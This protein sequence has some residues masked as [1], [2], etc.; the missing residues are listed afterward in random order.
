MKR[1]NKKGFT[2]VELLAAIVILAVLMLVGAQAVGTILNNSNANSLVNSLDMAIK[3]ATMKYAEGTLETCPT[4]DDLD[5]VL[6]YDKNQYEIK[7]CYSTAGD[8]LTVKIIADKNGKFKNTKCKHGNIK[9]SD[10]FEKTGD[11]LKKEVIYTT[12]EKK[13]DKYKFEC[14]DIGDEQLQDDGTKKTV[15]NFHIIKRVE[16]TD[17]GE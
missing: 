9:N 8:H 1:L 12:T 5:D 16:I 10:A 14:Y 13:I 4:T 7:A 17:D 3:Q 2:L 11:A 6:T 15:S